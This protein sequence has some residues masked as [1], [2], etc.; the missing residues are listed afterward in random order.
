MCGSLR[1]GVMP[2][3][4]PIAADPNS[5]CGEIPIAITAVTKADEFLAAVNSAITLAGEWGDPN[6][7]IIITGSH[8]NIKAMALWRRPLTEAEKAE[9]AEYERL[10][11]KFG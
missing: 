3:A 1:A 5:L 2:V 9:R 8:G 7:T 4:K 6:P 11:K 10:K